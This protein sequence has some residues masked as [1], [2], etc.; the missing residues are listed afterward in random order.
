MVIRWPD[1]DVAIPARQLRLACRCAHCREE[2]SGA[3]LLDPTTVPDDVHAVTI[4]LVGSYAMKV[5]WSDG[6]DT[7]LYSWDYLRTIRPAPA[8]E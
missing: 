2:M 6:H 7:G 5:V 8:E 1:G 4:S 3:P